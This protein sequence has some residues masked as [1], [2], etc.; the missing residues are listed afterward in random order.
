MSETLGMP[1][2]DATRG[3]NEEMP[4]VFGSGTNENTWASRSLEGFPPGLAHAVAAHRAKFSSAQ[5]PS[6]HLASRLA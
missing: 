5:P 1:C 2:G 3:F 6:R 4:V